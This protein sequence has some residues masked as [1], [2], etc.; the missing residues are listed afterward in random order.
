[1][2]AENRRAAIGQEVAHG[3]RALEAARVLRDLGLPNDSL[4]RLYYALFHFVSA[5][6]LTEGVEPRSHKAIAGLLGRH[7]LSSGVLSAE[8]VAVVSRT[9]ASRDLA[10]YERAWLADDAALGRA[11]SE[12]E[13]LL[14]KITESLEKGGWL[15]RA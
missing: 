5:M 10:D 11:F 9:Y 15:E 8:D 1:M 4:S 7:F 3:R 14:E 6:L 2:T 13:P 12:V